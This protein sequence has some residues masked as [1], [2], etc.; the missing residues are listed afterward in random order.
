VDGALIV[1]ESV[2]DTTARFSVFEF[3]MI[4]AYAVTSTD[5]DPM[6]VGVPE[7]RPVAALI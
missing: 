4:F 1:R 6:V 5:E 3:D 2:L 7:M